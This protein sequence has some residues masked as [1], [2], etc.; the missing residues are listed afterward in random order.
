MLVAAQGDRQAR[1]RA[2]PAEAVGFVARYFWKRMTGQLGRFGRAAVVFGTPL[3]LHDMAAGGAVDVA[4]LARAMQDRLMAQMPVLP[5]PLLCAALVGWAGVPRG[6]RSGPRWTACALPCLRARPCSCPTVTRRPNPCA[7]CWPGGSCA[8][9]TAYWS[10]PRPIWW[11]SMPARCR[12]NCCRGCRCSRRVGHKISKTCK[13]GL[14]S[15]AI[16]AR[17]PPA[18]ERFCIAAVTGGDH[19]P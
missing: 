5:V 14:H 19:G 1:F 13:N 8:T 16:V 7:P 3:S 12:Q 15:F 9:K 11:P 18:A 6:P 10:S 2:T 17:S 4:Q